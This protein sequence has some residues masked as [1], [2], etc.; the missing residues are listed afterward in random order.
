[1]RR[2]LVVLLAWLM[3][4]VS[5]ADEDDTRFLREQTQRAA[6]QRAKAEQTLA[7]PPGTLVYEGQA[8]QVNDSLQALEPAIYMAI[9]SNQWPLLPNFITRYQNLPGHRPA[10][11]AMAQSLLARFN[12]QYS[13]ALQHMEQASELEPQDARIRLELARLWF[14]DQQDKKARTG[15][16]EALNAGLPLYAQQLVQQYQQALEQRAGWHGSIATGGGYNSNINQANG[17]YSCLNSIAGIC[18]FE[19][20]MPEAIGSNLL[21][22]EFSAQRRINLS[23]NHNLHISPISYGTYYSRTNQDEHASIND[24]SQNLGI[25]KAGYQYLSARNHLLLAPYFEHNYRNRHHAYLAHGLELEWRHSLNQQWQFG[26]RLNAK[27]YSYTTEGK[28]LGSDHNQ[29]DL[30]LNAS[31]A[32]S[33][34]T[35]LYGGLTLTRQKY[36]A[37]VA[38]SREW[39]LRGGIYH[40]FSGAAGAFVNATAIY[41]ESLN[42]KHDFFLGERRQDQQQVYILG[43]GLNNWTL[44]GMTP[45]LRLRHSINHS[46]LDWAFS[47]DQTEVNVLLRKRF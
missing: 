24:Y 13:Q 3:V 26:T 32:P 10:L 15:F 47:F 5:Q 28:K 21:K 29:Y 34:Q 20:K 40:A 44:A 18:L 27:H 2:T 46:N 4:P 22:Y 43:A 35:S 6:E 31:F 37:D 42:D 33:A 23:G 11:A 14:E 39:A 30:D 17:H 38:S 45:E 41:R 36:D 19:R 25:F 9:N 8:Y 7:P 16:L 1:M 12:N